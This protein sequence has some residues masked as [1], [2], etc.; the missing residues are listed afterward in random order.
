MARA[1]AMFKWT[2]CSPRNMGDA[3]TR[4]SQLNGEE[5]EEIVE[6]L[7]RVG[8]NGFAARVLV[9]LSINGPN[10]SSGLQKICG[11]RQ[12][13]VSIAISHL[14]K[15]GIIEVEITNNGGRG[16]PKHI[17]SLI[18]DF[19]EATLPI[20]NKA[21]EKLE[22]MQNQISRLKELSDNIHDLQY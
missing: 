2:S 10:D 3:N 17:Y 22:T 18:G 6:L 11:L 20:V 7:K 13:E 1:G 5:I 8:T 14:K 16:R 12:P 21:K 9:S 19:K 15:N 4:I